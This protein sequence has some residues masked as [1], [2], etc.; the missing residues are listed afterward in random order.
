[1]LGQALPKR[2]SNLKKFPGILKPT[3]FKTQTAAAMKLSDDEYMRMWIMD[4]GASAD[5][6]GKQGLID[7]QLGRKEEAVETMCMNT[8]NGMIEAK[9][10]ININMTP[11]QEKIKPYV[12]RGSPDLLTVGRRCRALG[13]DFHWPPFSTEPVL[14]RP[15]GKR[16]KLVSINDVPY[17]PVKGEASDTCFRIKSGDIRNVRDHEVDPGIAL[18]APVTTGVAPGSVKVEIESNP[19]VGDDLG[20]DAGGAAA[21][22]SAVGSDGVDAA[23]PPAVVADSSGSAA[24][25][26]APPPPPMSEADRH[27]A[28]IAHKFAVEEYRKMM[29]D[30]QSPVHKFSHR[31]LKPSC[32]HCVAGRVQT[33]RRIKGILS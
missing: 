13:F 22:H 26:V 15:D 5:C 24:D 2:P 28:D 7:S 25:A 16:I 19:N 9:E 33:K 17:L 4:T 29:A 11:L 3:V 14:T 6:M 18:S 21:E 20:A 10:V 8:A 27:D 31:V 32:K 12:L 23:G 30:A 1:M